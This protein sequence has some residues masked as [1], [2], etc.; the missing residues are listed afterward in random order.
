MTVEGGG[1]SLRSLNDFVEFILCCFW[2]VSS[3]CLLVGQVWLQLPFA[4][5][6]WTAWFGCGGDLAVCAVVV[7]V[8]F[9]G[10]QCHKGGMQCTFG[11]GTDRDQMDVMMERER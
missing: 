5:T 7:C 9:G 4:E 6:R 11:H 1:E 2:G 8:R 3:V 10:Y